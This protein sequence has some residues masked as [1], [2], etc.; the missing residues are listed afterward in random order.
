MNKGKEGRKRE[1]VRW[2]PTRAR[3][4]DHEELMPRGML[5]V[6]VVSRDTVRGAIRRKVSRV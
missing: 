4:R 3:E 2:T 5:T 1:N 6:G